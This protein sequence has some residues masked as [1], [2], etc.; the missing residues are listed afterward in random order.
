MP[1]ASLDPRGQHAGDGQAPMPLQHSLT[2]IGPHVNVSTGTQVDV[3]MRTV[4]D[5][6]K[7][8]SYM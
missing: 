2:Y 5:H 8:Y 4:R 6:T 7:V 1:Y 3:E